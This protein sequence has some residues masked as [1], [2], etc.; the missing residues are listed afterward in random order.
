MLSELAEP[1]GINKENVHTL[2]D[3]ESK[4]LTMAKLVIPSCTTLGL[5]RT[6]LLEF[7][8]ETKDSV[9]PIRDRYYPISHFAIC[10]GS[11]V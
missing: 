10:P 6:K 4:R 9:E 1:S 11:V 3:R 7:K 5:G 8:I 2:S